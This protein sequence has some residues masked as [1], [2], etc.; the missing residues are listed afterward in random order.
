[1]PL[2]AM[3]SHSSYNTSVS[4]YKHHHAHVSKSCR[5]HPS[6]NPSRSSHSTACDPGTAHHQAPTPTNLTELQPSMPQLQKKAMHQERSS[7]PNLSPSCLRCHACRIRPDAHAARKRLPPT[8]TPSCSC[9]GIRLR[10]GEPPASR[11]LREPGVACIGDPAR[12]ALA[13]EAAF[14][15]LFVGRGDGV[16]RWRDCSCIDAFTSAA[17]ERRLWKALPDSR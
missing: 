2:C 12:M 16:R 5:N 14:A 10:C 9:L 13:G 7:P 8:G 6:S 17:L 4:Q 3:G 1:M 15:L 11:C